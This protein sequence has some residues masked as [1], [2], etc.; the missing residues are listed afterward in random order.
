MMMP[1]GW[2][3]VSVAEALGCQMPKVTQT[4][5]IF[6]IN[7]VCEHKIMQI[8]LHVQLQCNILRF[9]QYNHFIKRGS[10]LAIQPL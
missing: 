8:N 5:I 9:E 4:Q 6:H 3:A 1:K 10:A 7:F 2:H